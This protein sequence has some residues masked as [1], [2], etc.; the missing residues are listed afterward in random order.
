MRILC[1]DQFQKNRQIKALR[2]P[3]WSGVRICDEEKF[4]SIE[5]VFSL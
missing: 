4:E 5:L 2:F 3:Q 1:H